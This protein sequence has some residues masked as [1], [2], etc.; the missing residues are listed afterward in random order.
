[1]AKEYCVTGVMVNNEMRDVLIVKD[2]SNMEPLAFADT[3][4]IVVEPDPM[5]GQAG[6]VYITEGYIWKT[7][8]P[9]EVDNYYVYWFLLAKD[10]GAAAIANQLAEEKAA[11]QEAT[12]I[13]LGVAE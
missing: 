12:N 7:Y 10:Q 4:T 1:M 9:D 13:L 5:T 11:L 6:K 3:Q 2:E 8:P